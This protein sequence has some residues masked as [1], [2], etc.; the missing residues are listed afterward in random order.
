MFPPVAANQAEIQRGAEALRSGRLVVFPT[1]TVYGLGANALDPHAVAR[2]FAAKGRPADNPLIVHISDISELES[3]AKTP[4]AVAYRLFTRFSPGPLTV[5]L[6]RNSRLP[7][8]VS[9]G[10]PSVAVRIPSH[11][12]A[13]ALLRACGFPV[14]APS[15]NR[16]GRPSPTDVERAREDLGDSVD[17]YLDGGPCEVGLESTVVR[18]VMLPGETAKG[19][20]GAP[21][22]G[23]RG[24]APDHNALVEILR[25][26]A[27]T[28]EML[29]E[30]LGEEAVVA[31]GPGAGEQAAEVVND[32]PDGGQAPA[33]LSP[34]TRHAHYMPKAKVVPFSGDLPRPLDGPAA[35]LLLSTPPEWPP[36]VLA[37]ASLVLSF[38]DLDGYAA[39]LFRAFRKAD[40][41][42][43]RV[44][45]AELPPPDGLGRAL[46]DRILRAAGLASL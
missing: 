19:L 8:A 5:V 46:R 39:Q 33:A 36:E 4:P 17:V 41:A 31:G 35:L 16:S 13:Q 43:C 27:V 15:A 29:A 32:A 11:P 28:R 23:R 25:E 12:V 2:I 37:A 18:I 34:G 26:G 10:L 9:A 6:S 42:G 38:D 14:A 7:P 24:E 30:A 21:A 44:V 45:Y 1:E 22:E 20:P 3:V 40:D